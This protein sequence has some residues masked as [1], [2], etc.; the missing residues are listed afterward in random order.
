MTQRPHKNMGVGLLW[1]FDQTA[2]DLESDMLRKPTKK[3]LLPILVDFQG[4]TVK[5]FTS[6]GLFRAYMN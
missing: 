4:N 1:Q 6:E 3:A 5:L 2:L